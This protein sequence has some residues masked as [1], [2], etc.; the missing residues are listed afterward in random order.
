MASS[1]STNLYIVFGSNPVYG[2]PVNGEIDASL[3]TTGNADT[4]FVY[5]A[6][7]AI[8]EGMAFDGWVWL[9]G[10]VGISTTEST[11]SVTNEGN[12]VLK[13]PRNSADNRSLS[14][15]ADNGWT[16]LDEGFQG[17]ETYDGLIH[18]AGETGRYVDSAGEPMAIVG[19][20]RRALTAELAYDANGGEAA[21]D[22]QTLTSGTAGA[23]ST[24]V[25]TRSGYVFLGWGLSSTDAS[26]TYQ[27]GDSIT[28]T[29]DT[30]LY[31]LWTK[32]VTLSYDAQGGSPTPDSDTGSTSTTTA[33]SYTTTVTTD[34]PSKSGYTFL[35]WSD[36]TP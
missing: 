20:F 24:S 34:T 17:F 10:G 7:S 35:G 19:L 2:S 22:S 12:Y 23:V 30:T 1:T 33:T 36:E 28:I 31:A 21:P 6:P 32:T 16:V 13:V 18:Q 15:T 26:P 14:W 25:P 9:S 11:L 5:P 4:E 29:A 3:T 27:P 8:P